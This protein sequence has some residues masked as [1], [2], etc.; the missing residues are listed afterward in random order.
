MVTRLPPRKS[1]G[2]YGTKGKPIELKANFVPVKIDL[3]KL[4]YIYHYDVEVSAQKSPDRDLPKSLN[5]QVV[6]QFMKTYEGPIFKGISFAYDG[7]KN[8]YSNKQISTQK[9]PLRQRAQF[10]TEYSKP[11]G[12]GPEM[13]IVKIRYAQEINCQNIAQTLAGRGELDFT[14]VQALD[15]VMMHGFK[16]NDSYTNV[17]SNFFLK[18]QRRAVE[19][20]CGKEI[21]FGFHQSLRACEGQMMLNIDVA[22]T[23]FYKGQNLLDFA[24]QTL[25]PPR[26]GRDGT[27]P[28]PKIL[29]NRPLQDNQRKLLE[30]ELKN[31]KIETRHGKHARHYKVGRLLKESAGTKKFEHDGTI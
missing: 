4:S 19:L 12:R 17:G 10:E 26:R 7:K 5:A 25:F 8:I 28:P 23:T 27:T 18:Q 30:K 31:V 22:A 1:L 3:K 20:G 2:G 13:F 11:G 29:A 9:I 6:E 15:V 14:L 24:S 16:M 21:W